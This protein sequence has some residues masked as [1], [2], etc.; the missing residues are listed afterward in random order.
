[1]YKNRG[2][3]LGPELSLVRSL[4]SSD[5]VIFSR[6]ELLFRGPSSRP[7]PALLATPK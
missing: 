2:A 3:T 5:L 7:R 4:A 6:F 1:M